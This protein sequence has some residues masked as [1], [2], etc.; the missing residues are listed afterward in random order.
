MMLPNDSLPR[1]H[2]RYARVMVAIA[3]ATS[4]GGMPRVQAAPPTVDELT[5]AIRHDRDAFFA[6]KSYKLHFQVD[7]EIHEGGTFAYK[8]FTVTNIRRGADLH[9]IVQYPEGSLRRSEV[10]PENTR[11]LVFFGGSA[12]DLEGSVMQISP[13]IFTQHF[14]YNQYTDYQHINVYKDLPPAAGNTAPFEITQP[15]LPETVEKS[16]SS[17]RVREAPET[18][19]GAS[20]W[21]LERPEIDTIWVDATGLVHQRLLHWAKGEPRS[22]LSKS[23]DFKPVA[24]GLK[25]PTKLV[26]DHYNNPSVDPESRWDKIA[27][28]LTIVLTG[29]EFNTVKDEDFLVS[30]SPGD[31]VNDYVRRVQYRVPPPG[32]KPFEAALKV[33][34]LEQNPRGHYFI[35]INGILFGLLLAGVIGHRIWRVYHPRVEPDNPA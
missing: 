6:Q 32:E 28:T 1:F 14:T 26:V 8:S 12:I 33:A 10:T 13:L 34:G 17:Y 25:L 35:I 16:P 3:V 24:P 15:F 21:I 29:S 9:T 19:D 18:I 11:H 2:N 30:P 4:V 22:V 5:A 31:T 20:C 27:Y 23:F 7:S